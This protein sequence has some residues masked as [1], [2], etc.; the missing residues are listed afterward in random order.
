[1]SVQQGKK[2]LAEIKTAAQVRLV[3]RG[4]GAKWDVA[5]GS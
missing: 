3:G 5:E 4:R 1:M 2:I